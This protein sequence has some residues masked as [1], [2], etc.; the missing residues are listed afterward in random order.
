MAVVTQLGATVLS[1]RVQIAGAAA[2]D[3]KVELEQH[4]LKYAENRRILL[5]VYM[6]T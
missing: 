1:L 4:I 2:F 5:Q 6:C 3:C